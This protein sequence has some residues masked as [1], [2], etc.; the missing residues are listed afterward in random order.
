MLLNKKAIYTTKKDW[1][2]FWNGYQP[3]IVS[4]V[5]FEELLRKYLKPNPSLSCIEIGCFPGEF[6]IFMNKNFKYK[7]YGI[8][9]NIRSDTFWDNMR[10]NGVSECTYYNEDFTTWNTNKRYDIVCSFGFIEHFNN[11]DVIID[12]HLALL[13]EQGVLVLGCPNFRYAQ[14]LFHFLFDR[15]NLKRHYLEIMSITKIREIIEKNNLSVIF[16]GY[17]RT[18]EFW[19]DKLHQKRGIVRIFLTL[20]ITTAK[21]INRVI[22]VPNRYFSPYILCIAQKN[23]S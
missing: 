18:V 11:Y 7:I 8:D 6:L 10:L 14:Y 4:H 23:K 1:D 22:N 20:I 21:V 16:I 5:L 19:V 13:S 15:D 9:F 12:K 17:Y 2:I 3:K